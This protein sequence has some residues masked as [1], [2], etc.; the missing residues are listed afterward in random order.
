MALDTFAPD[1]PPQIAGTGGSLD[2]RILEAN[3]GDGARQAAPDGLNS[4][5][6]SY[7]L[8]WTAAPNAVFEYVTAFYQAHGKTEPFWYTPPGRSTP[9][10]FCF[11][12]PLEDRGV[13][14]A[15]QGFQVPIQQDFSAGS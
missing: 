15:A 11:S 4:L 1:W 10:K 13:T 14:G 12:G 9:R 7:T 2:Q 3:F 6:E 8:V 5:F